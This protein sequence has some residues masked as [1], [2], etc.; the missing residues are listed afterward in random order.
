MNINWKVAHMVD[1]GRVHLLSKI[2]VHIY[3]WLDSVELCAYLA[4]GDSMIHQSWHDSIEEA[5]TAAEKLLS[6]WRGGE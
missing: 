6:E 4:D 2:T 3:Q 1:D 5:K